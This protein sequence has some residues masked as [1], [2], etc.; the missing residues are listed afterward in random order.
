MVQ[1]IGVTAIWRSVL[2]EVDP[3]VPVTVT[4]YNP[5]G[6]VWIVDTVRTLLHEQPALRV[7]LLGLVE[8]VSPDGVL[9]AERATVPEKPLRLFNTTLA[10]LEL[11]VA[12]ERSSGVEETEKS[13]VLVRGVMNSPAGTCRLFS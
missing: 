10:V 6:V 13:P 5:T 2:W 11:P 1:V 3:L 12:T 7:R 4:L 8:R 9:V